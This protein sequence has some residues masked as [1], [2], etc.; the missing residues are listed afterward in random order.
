MS[1]LYRESHRTLQDQFDTRRLADRIEGMII[2]DV[3]GEQD[4]L[5]IESRE[6]FFL[7]TVDPGGQ[8]TVSFKG[9]P[10]GFVKVVDD[11]TIAFPSYD[12][13][14]MFYS[15]GNLAA[16]PEI[17][18]L[19]IDFENPHRVR[20]HGSASIES[21]DPLLSDYHEAELIVRVTLSKMWINCPRYIPKFQRVM[22]SRYVPQQ[23]G[24]AP[25]AAWKRIDAVQDV[26]PARD[27]GRTAAA[28]GVITMDDWVELLHK[29]EG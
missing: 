20:F 23:S 19:F 27:H 25:L 3:I 24:R 21:N 5:F 12:G 29:G 8:P 15:M 13:N 11:T 22:P 16:K 7:S 18:I 6:F 10:S 17:G 2:S 14:G 28:G 9:G 1:D 26:L 4:K